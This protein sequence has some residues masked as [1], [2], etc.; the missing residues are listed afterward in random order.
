[1]PYDSINFQNM[2]EIR[3]Q[4]NINSKLHEHAKA[5][6]YTCTMLKI[7]TIVSV[8]QNYLIFQMRFSIIDHC[9]NSGI[10]EASPKMNSLR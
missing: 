7:V 8:I 10:V 3:F 4:D 1:M 2:S 6:I 5:L 9:A